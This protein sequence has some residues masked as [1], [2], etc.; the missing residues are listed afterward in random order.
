[1]AKQQ[2]IWGLSQDQASGIQQIYKNKLASGLTPAQAQEA[3]KADQ[4]FSRAKAQYQATANPTQN[5]TPPSPATPEQV[6]PIVQQKQESPTAQPTTPPVQQQPQAETN[7]N[8]SISSVQAPQAITPPPTVEKTTTITPEWQTVVKKETPW[9]VT[10]DWNIGKGREQDILNNLNDWYKN[11][12][13]IQKAIMT[14]DYNSFKQSYWYDTADQTKKNMLDAFFQARQPKNSESFFKTLVTGQKIENNKYRE[15]PEARNAQHRF[16]VISPYKWASID[17][18]YN[19]MVSGTITPWSQAYKDLIQINGGIET[20]DMLLAKKK[21]ET[22]RQIDKINESWARQNADKTWTQIIDKP[23]ATQSISDNIIS[24]K[25]FD[26]AQRYKEKVSQDPETRELAEKI[27]A[28]SLRKKEI[29]RIRSDIFKNIVKNNPWMT[30]GAANLKAKYESE[31]FDDEYN[32]LIDTLNV[33]SADL[34]YKTSLLEKEFDYEFKQAQTEEERAYQA[35]QAEQQFTRQKELAQ[36]QQELGLQWKQA[37]FEQ[38][39]KQKAQIA[40]DPVMATQDVIDTYAKLWILPERSNQEIIQSVQDD[41]ANGMTLGQS[42]TNLNKAFQSKPQYQA[43]IAPKP[44]TAGQVWTKLDDSTLY[45]Q[46]TGETKSVK[47]GTPVTSEEI[48]SFTTTR[49]WSTN[50]QCGELVND[51]WKKV[52]G[53]S[54]GIG[55]TLN[56]KY[57]AISDIGRSD[58]PVVGGI[59]VS[60]PLNNNVGHAGIVSKVNDDGSIEV[61]EANAA[62]K[63]SGQPP[64][65]KTYSAQQVSQMRFSQAPQIKSQETKTVSTSL[66]LYRKYVEDGAIPPA[67]TLKSMGLTADQFTQNAQAGYEQALKQQAQEISSQNKTLNIDYIP[68][69]YS[70]ISATQREKLNESVT[71]IWEVDSRMKQLMDIFQKVGTEIMPTKEKTLM[72]SLRQQIILKAKEV[73]NLGVL[74]WPDLWILESI[75]PATDAIFSFNENTMAKLQWIRNNYRSDAQSKAINYGA[76]LQFKDVS[77]QQIS[78]ISKQIQ[79]RITSLRAQ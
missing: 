18:L 75:F 10:P 54:A 59:F 16:D 22:K 50:I 62:G 61:R 39:M 36:F 69:I 65:T 45:N 64:I 35:Q 32:N 24:K 74:N 23:D 43:A 67:A 12:Q 42:L 51:Y 55:D 40:S 52:T 6:A 46:A 73:E 66:P 14:W 4:N 58:T 30:M 38:Q 7:L 8:A 31:A 56:D 26:Y 28:D 44:T 1:M 19:W 15:S 25:G 63:A 78:D 60:N 27:K 17:S 41:L 48:N 70:N 57:G 9:V 68:S 33:N 37:E 21:L 53:S 3:I 76:K 13:A 47:P 34:R 72:Q 49:N 2:N 77:D 20:P 11:D 79:D 29:E 5:I 71:K